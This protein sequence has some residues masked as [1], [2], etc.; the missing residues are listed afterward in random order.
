M[1]MPVRGGSVREAAPGCC[2]F[3]PQFGT[4]GGV[5]ERCSLLTISKGLCEHGD[6]KRITLKKKKLQEE[7]I[8]LGKEV[9]QPCCSVLVVVVGSCCPI[10]VPLPL[11]RCG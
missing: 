4:L 11:C 6:L 2:C 5:N 3:V 10:P 7:S 1:L 8:S 9:L